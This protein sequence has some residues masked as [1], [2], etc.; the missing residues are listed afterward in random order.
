M[1]RPFLSEPSSEQLMKK[2][3]RKELFGVLKN[4]AVM[5]IALFILIACI[6]DAIDSFHSKAPGRK[7][8]VLSFLIF[9][10]P[11]WILVFYY[12]IKNLREHLDNFRA[13]D[14]APVF[15]RY[16]TPGELAEILA[17]PE[18]VQ[19]LN[20]SRVVL[21]RE[22]IMMRGDIHSYLP[23]SALRAVHV[24]CGYRNTL[25]IDVLAENVG[26]RS[27]FYEPLPPLQFNS[28]RAK[29]ATEI[30]RAHLAAY[31]PECKL[32]S[33]YLTAL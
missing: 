11:A 25:H 1:K 24:V 9:T 2:A 8:E 27:Y 32:I 20:S 6:A 17:S 18:N 33:P 23:L 14:S 5:G 4:L 22:Y 16:G 26:K 3:S 28:T 13:E 12:P 31:A 29:E 19:V 10:S 30:L 7:A 15:A 21:T